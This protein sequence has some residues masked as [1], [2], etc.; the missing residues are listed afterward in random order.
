MSFKKTEL[1]AHIGR[2]VWGGNDGN[3]KSMSQ[4]AETPS[5]GPEVLLVGNMSQRFLHKSWLKELGSRF[6]HKKK[7]EAYNVSSVYITKAGGNEK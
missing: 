5:K 4:Q 6:E 3:N 2:L 1:S 7:R